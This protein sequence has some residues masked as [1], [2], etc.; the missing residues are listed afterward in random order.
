MHLGVT[1]SVGATSTATGSCAG[2]GGG[3]E[4]I[5]VGVA[6]GAAAAGSLHVLRWE[7]LLALLHSQFE[8]FVSQNFFLS[9]VWQPTT[10][11]SSTLHVL[12]VALALRDHTQPSLFSQTFFLEIGPQSLA[13]HVRRP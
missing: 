12:R 5:R 13:L 7:P 10:I 9:N 1:S 4:T 2:V 3:A 11:V 6:V 8:S